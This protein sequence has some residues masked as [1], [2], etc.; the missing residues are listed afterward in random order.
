[1]LLCTVVEQHDDQ[2]AKQSK[3]NVP[4]DAPGEGS[5]VGEP[6]VLR[7]HAQQH[8]RSGQDIH[9][10]GQTLP[11]LHMVAFAPD[12]IQQHVKDGHGDGSDPLAQTQRNCV[13]FQ[14]GGTQCQRTGDKVEGI[15]CTQHHS[16]KAEQLELRAALA[17]ADH[18]DAH[19]EHGGQI[20]DVENGFNDCTHRVCSFFKLV[21]RKYNIVCVNRILSSCS[22]DQVEHC[23][24]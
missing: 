18:T 11:A 10:N 16:H 14:T 3:G 24:F 23:S 21:W 4:Q 6:L 9:G 7:H 15:T 8:T 22:T 2:Q 1:M 19:R 5:L 20:E 12:I 13:V 17:A